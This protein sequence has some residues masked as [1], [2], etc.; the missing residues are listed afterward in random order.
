[1]VNSPLNS[2]GINTAFARVPLPRIGT[3]PNVLHTDLK[4]Q[5]QAI[6]C[7]LFHVRRSTAKLWGEKELHPFTRLR[8][9]NETR[10]YTSTR[11]Q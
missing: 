2:M 10:A 6:Q 7:C 5:N 8:V 1:M 11:Y 4:F 3:L 9:V